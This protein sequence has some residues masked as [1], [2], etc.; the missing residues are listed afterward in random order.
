M[1]NRAHSINA[2]RASPNAYSTAGLLLS[3]A[4][5]LPNP[6]GPL[7]RRARAI[8]AHGSLDDA[9]SVLALLLDAVDCG[10]AIEADGCLD[11]G[12]DA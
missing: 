10:M 12:F 5:Q 8:A 3:L 9:A 4:S 7:G 1:T 2:H 11:D 6:A